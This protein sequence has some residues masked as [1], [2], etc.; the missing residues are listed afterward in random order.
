MRWRDIRFEKPTEADG[1]L[2]SP[3]ELKAWQQWANGAEVIH[4]GDSR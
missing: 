2:Q 4:M 3:V 1:V